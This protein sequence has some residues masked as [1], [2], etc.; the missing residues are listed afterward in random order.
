MKR[1]AVLLCCS[2]FSL[3]AGAQQQQPQPPPQQQQQQQGQQQP[4]VEPEAARRLKQM[5][6]YLGGLRSFRVHSEAADE[7]VTRDGQKIQHLS[8]SRLAARRPNKLRVER[9]GPVADVVFR[10]D[11]S[12]CTLFG[13]KTK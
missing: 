6:D 9:V 10:Y 12:Q 3:S 1:Y 13:N 7:F 2:L 8:E 11:G 4:T 5:S